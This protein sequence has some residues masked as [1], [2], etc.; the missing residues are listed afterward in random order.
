M[1]DRRD[2]STSSR[3]KGD[4]SENTVDSPGQIKRFLTAMA[5]NAPYLP[6]NP[7]RPRPFGG[8]G[9]EGVKKEIP[10]NRIVRPSPQFC[11]TP[12]RK[13]EARYRNWNARDIRTYLTYPTD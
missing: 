9:A 12:R 1:P 5:L 3:A 13:V 10:S 11:P 4:F 2:F 7:L 8:K 6:L